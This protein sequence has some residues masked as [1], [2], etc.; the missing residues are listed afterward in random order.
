MYNKQ[1]V[2]QVWPLSRLKWREK[3]VHHK[4]KWPQVARKHNEV[5]LR[6]GVRKR[7]NNGNKTVR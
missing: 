2:S 5:K 1:R 6:E 7:D 3:E 4:I